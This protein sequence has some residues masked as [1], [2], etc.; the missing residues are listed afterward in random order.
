MQNQV[1][2]NLEEQ[3]SYTVKYDCNKCRDTTYIL[4]GDEAFP[5]SCKEV[6]RAKK[7]L[8]DSGISEE[9]SKKTFDNFDYSRNVQ[10]IDSY[11]VA[12]SYVR[13]FDKI[14]NNRKNSVIFM[15]SVGGGKTHLSIWDIGTVLLDLSK[16]LWMLVY[17]RV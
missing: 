3:E 2:S 11:T 5:C 10:T 1:K 9:F 16:I 14:K 7:I 17:M 13:D 6:R 12:R 15:G 8:D 4:V